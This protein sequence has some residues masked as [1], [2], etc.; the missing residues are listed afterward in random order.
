MTARYHINVFYSDEDECFVAE[1]PDLD[2]VSALGATPHEAVGEV[3]AARA[4]PLVANR[5]DE[6]L[7]GGVRVPRTREVAHAVR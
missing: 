6:P 4:R 7:P 3:E 5:V 1:V 2:G